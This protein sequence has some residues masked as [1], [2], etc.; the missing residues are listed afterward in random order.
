MQEFIRIIQLDFG[1]APEPF[2]MFHLISLLLI[3]VAITVICLFLRVNK[4]GGRSEKVY[5]ILFLTIAGITFL[6]EVYKQIVITFPPDSEVYYRW[7]QFPWMLCSMPIYLMPIAALTKNE[8]IRKVLNFFIATYCLFGG[9]IT[10]SQPALVL[11]SRLGISFQSMFVHGTWVC[12]GIYLYVS[13]RV[14]LDFKTYLWATCLFISIFA[15]GQIL[16]EIQ[17]YAG[18]WE[19]NKEILK[20]FGISYHI[21]PDL[22]FLPDIQRSVGG[23]VMDPNYSNHIIGGDMFIAYLTVVLIY[24]SIM[25]SMAT[26]IFL[27]GAGIPY[28]IEK[29]S[30]AAPSRK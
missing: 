9:L 21:V 4:K 20:T 14:K 11:D 25:I 3:A 1:E 17:Y 29:I 7:H 15:V 12:I 30:R 6:L 13:G 19:A 27:I 28:L 10:L 22:P 16:N 26:L 2:G 18:L 5:K 23:L 24:L 8:K